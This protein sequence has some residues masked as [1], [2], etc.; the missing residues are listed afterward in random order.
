[1]EWHIWDFPDS[2]YLKFNEEY[3]RKLFEKLHKHFGSHRNIGKGLGFHYTTIV[4][5]LKSGYDSGGFQTSTNIKIIKRIL[6]IFPEEKQELEKNVIAYRCRA[7]LSVYNPNLPIK[8]TP[9]IYSIICHVIAD[10]SAGKGKT[11]Y[12]SNSLKE[13]LNEFRRNLQIFGRVKTNPYFYRKSGVTY[14]MFPKAITDILSH[15]F[16]VKFTF[17][18]KLPERLFEASADCIKAAIRAMFD[19]EGTVSTLFAITQ[20]SR[21]ILLQLKK[22]LLSFE[23]ETGNVTYSEPRGCYNLSV[24]TKSYDNFHKLIG[25]T[26]IDKIYNL[27]EKV[28]KRNYYIESLLETKIYDLLLNSSPLTKHQ[29]AK[30]FKITPG[31]AVACLRTLEKK[32]KV[33]RKFVGINKPYLWYLDL[34]T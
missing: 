19:D 33:K 4:S 10:G 30:E 29:I 24:L 26:S 34:R 7:G 27:K 23:I 3:R 2:I 8:E 15:V 12:Y 32:S 17:P 25:L 31:N 20:K 18:N 11:P 16:N 6:E 5:C 22:I 1:M 9:E 21:N 14:L 13:L 28:N